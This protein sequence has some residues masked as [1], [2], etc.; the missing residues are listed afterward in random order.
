VSQKERDKLKAE[1]KHLDIEMGRITETFWNEVVQKYGID[2]DAEGSS[3]NSIEK[4][5]EETDEASASSGSDPGA[6]VAVGNC[7][8][9]PP[10]DALLETDLAA[11]QVAENEDC[12]AGTPSSFAIDRDLNLLPRR[13]KTL[14]ALPANAL[15][16]H[17][18]EGV[19]DAHHDNGL[20]E[21]AKTPSGQ[22]NPSYSMKKTF[23][24]DSA[25]GRRVESSE[26][27]VQSG[28]QALREDDNKPV[29]SH[30]QKSLAAEVPTAR[31]EAGSQSKNKNTIS[32]DSDEGDD[33]TRKRQL[34][35]IAMHNKP[36]HDPDFE[37]FKRALDVAEAMMAGFE[38]EL[39]LE[40]L[41]NRKSEVRGT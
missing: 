41:E 30:I 23:T 15:A 8:T 27:D 28:L 22:T 21:N 40:T 34:A 11:Q 31:E 19:F 25:I 12:D 10:K 18:L 3:T 1:G 39:I 5:A 38:E 33:K 32:A 26:W 17:G 14:P 7:N 13:R 35:F 2:R 36:I 20:Y 37:V 24:F 29:A 16:E 9:S 4:A 6:A